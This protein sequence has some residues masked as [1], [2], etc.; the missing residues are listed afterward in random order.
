M[1]TVIIMF[2]LFAEKRRKCL[3][4][5]AKGNFVM[6]EWSVC[7]PTS[8]VVVSSCQKFEKRW[9]KGTNE[10]L[11]KTCG[12]RNVLLLYVKA[13]EGRVDSKISDI[14]LGLLPVGSLRLK[15]VLNMRTIRSIASSSEENG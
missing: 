12:R 1:S 6:A 11:A 7:A 10:T 2:L 14:G 4:F 15:E 13:S 5:T 9:C 8:H 3:L